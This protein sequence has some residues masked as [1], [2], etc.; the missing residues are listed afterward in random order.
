ME[1][2]TGEGMQRWMFSSYF[3]VG[4]G[5]ST[6]EACAKDAFSPH[7][8]ALCSARVGSRASCSQEWSDAGAYRREVKTHVWTSAV[9]NILQPIKGNQPAPALSHLFAP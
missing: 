5:C 7:L 6:V 9:S 1:Q 8:F 2:A 4:K 3:P